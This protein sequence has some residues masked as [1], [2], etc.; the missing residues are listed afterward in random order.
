[1]AEDDDSSAKSVAPLFELLSS[2]SEL[3]LNTDDD[4]ATKALAAN[5]VQA[6]S[7]TGFLRITCPDL[8][9]IALQEQALK[10]A[11]EVLTQNHNKN[12]NVI[13][14]PTDP[15]RYCMFSKSDDY[16]QAPAI[17]HKYTQQ[18]EK[19]KHV[20]LK[21]LALGLNLEQN[22]FSDLHSDNESALRLLL[23]PALSETSE[24]GNRCKEH[25]D[26]GSITLLLTDGVSGLEAFDS[27]SHQWKPVP[28]TQGAIIVNA[29]SL[30]EQWT[31]GKIPATLHR[32]AGPQSQGISASH[33]AILE[34]AAQQDR[35]S[36][37]FFADPNSNVVAA[38]ND[39]DGKN[40]TPN[41]MTVAEYIRYRSGNIND[42][43]SRSGVAFTAQEQERIS[44]ERPSSSTKG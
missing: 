31:G 6:F 29:G 19:V 32:V 10:A 15:K 2:S 7:E 27:G 4:T 30:L 12:K 21:L 39:K 23:Y 22:Y 3:F 44:T 26:Y 38:L 17:L 40:D 28:Y 37:A 24:T 35:I 43:T 14:H 13:S 11:R 9:P 36:L 5:L 34:Q 33:K 25:S 42:A 1:M 16:T 18:L 20:L 8:V 41:N